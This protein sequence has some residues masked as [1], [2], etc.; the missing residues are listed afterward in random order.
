MELREPLF[1]ARMGTRP[2]LG[3]AA[4]DRGAEVGAMG[5]RYAEQCPDGGQ[6]LA[7]SGRDVLLHIIPARCNQGE[8]LVL[9]PYQPVF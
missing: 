9:R 7:G 8:S 4:L 6:I 1:G 5:F 2:I 3:I